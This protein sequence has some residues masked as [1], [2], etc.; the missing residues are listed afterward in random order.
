MAEKGVLIKD[1]AGG[2]SIACRDSVQQDNDANNR[3]VQLVDMAARPA[4]IH[5]TNT[6]PVER[7]VTASDPIDLNPLPSG[8]GDTSASRLD[9]SDAEGFIFFAKVSVGAS[10]V[11]LT[12]TPVL[13]SDGTSPVAKALFPPV[14]LFPVAPNKN[15]NS[16]NHIYVG[17]GASDGLLT[18]VVYYPSMG[19]K[20]VAFHL[21]FSAP[22]TSCT[23][24]AYVVSCGGRIQ[25]IDENFIAGT[26]GGTAF[27]VSS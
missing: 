12:V 21:L 6:A 18:Q 9:V 24:S 14:Q 10:A 19:V 27:P 8:V 25:K 3:I 20:Q 16:G 23:F 15:A 5:E 26:F 22:P 7:T 1:Q 11:E 4:G 2:E 17:T 13:L